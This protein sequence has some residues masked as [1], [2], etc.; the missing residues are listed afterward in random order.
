MRRLHFE[1]RR[2]D[3]IIEGRKETVEWRVRGDQMMERER[4]LQDR[5]EG[6]GHRIEMKLN[7]IKWRMLQDEGVEGPQDGG[8]R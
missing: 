3:H 4:K 5:G 8:G 1:G 2:G 6:G 7:H